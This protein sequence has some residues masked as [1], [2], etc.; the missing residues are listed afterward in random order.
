MNWQDSVINFV[1]QYGFQIVGAIVILVVGALLA[2][3]LGK[4]TNGWLV[5]QALEP[6]IRLLVVRDRKSVV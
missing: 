4:L 3:W 1:V 5:K 2:K 6:P